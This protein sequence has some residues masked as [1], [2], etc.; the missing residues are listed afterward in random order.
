[1][2][3][4]TVILPSDKASI[5]HAIEAAKL[6]VLADAHAQSTSVASVAAPSVPRDE[7]ET[8]DRAPRVLI[9]DALAVV[10]CIKKTPIM[11]SIVHL[12]TACTAIIELVVIKYMEV[13]VFFDRYVEVSL[14]QNTRKKRVTC[15]AATTAGHVVPDGMSINTISLKQLLSCTSVHDAL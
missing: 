14:K 13:R 12:K 10:Q 1:M 4:Q 5:I 7:R 3:S 6:P 11:T 9:I 15:V 8:T 2:T